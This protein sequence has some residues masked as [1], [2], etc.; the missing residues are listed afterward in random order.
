MSTDERNHLFDPGLLGDINQPNAT[1]KLTEAFAQEILENIGVQVFN[2]LLCGAEEHPGQV[3]TPPNPGGEFPPVAVVVCRI[4]G[5]R[6]VQFRPGLTQ[7]DLNPDELQQICHVVLDGTEPKQ[8]CEVQTTNCL[9]GNV[10]NVCLIGKIHLERIPFIFR[11][12]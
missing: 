8:V 4:N 5:L 2:T 11:H 10:G 9:A 3:R 7:G 12:Y 1:S 6:S